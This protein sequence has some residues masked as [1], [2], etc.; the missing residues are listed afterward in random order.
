MQIGVVWFSYGPDGDLLLESMRS[1]CRTLDAAGH[2]KILYV[3]DDGFMPLSDEVRDRVEGE[4][5]AMY[6][7]Q[8]HPRNT[9]LLGPEHLKEQTMW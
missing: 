6:V 8:F 3:F 9:N 1:V 5:H 7:K 2:D 4:F